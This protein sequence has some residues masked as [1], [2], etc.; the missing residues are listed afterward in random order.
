MYGTKN[1]KFDHFN[2]RPHVQ[3]EVKKVFINT[4]TQRKK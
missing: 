4:E 2:A 1:P 3:K